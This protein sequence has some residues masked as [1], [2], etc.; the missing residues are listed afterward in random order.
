M[1]AL[2]KELKQ[3][4]RAIYIIAAMALFAFV[5]LKPQSFIDLWLTKDQQGSILFHLERFDEASTTFTN[6]RWQAFSLYG[7]E[8][9]DQAATL[10]SQFTTPQDGLARAN[11][12]AHNRRYVKARDMYQSILNKD[13]ENSA[14]KS[15]LTIVQAIIDEVNSLSES[16]K[17]EEGASSKELGDEPQIGDGAEKKEA[18]KQEVEQLSAEQ[19]LLDPAVNDMWLRQVQK[20]PARFLSQKFNMQNYQSSP[21][22]ANTPAADEGTQD[23]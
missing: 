20:D 17:P 15:N 2:K 22:K 14:A 13:P 1:V 19:L 11:A 10:Y 21:R 3:H 16:Q 5:Y 18:S 8:Q 7:A 6:T 4:K 9:F 23:D 12:L